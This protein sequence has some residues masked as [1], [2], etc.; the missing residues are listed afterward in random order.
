MS[1]S[2]IPDKPQSSDIVI[3]RPRLLLVIGGA[4]LLL[5]LY[6]STQVIGVLY[7]IVFPPLP[8]VPAEVRELRHENED[9]GVDQWLYASDL[10]ACEVVR[11]YQRLTDSCVI[12]PGRCGAGSEIDIQTPGQHIARCYGDQYFSI[13]AM[14]WRVNIATGNPNSEASGSTEFSLEREV[15]WT[16][17]IP[18]PTPTP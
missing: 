12:A 5:L 6:L 14:R 10:E 1:S 9:Y 13:F 17:S 4:A 7:A 15:Y 8:P 16:G 3:H 11:F 18:Q 2:G